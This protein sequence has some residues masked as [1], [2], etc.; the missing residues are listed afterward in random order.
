MAIW[1]RN[2]RTGNVW[3]LD[4]GTEHT[5]YVLSTGGYDVIPDP[6]TAPTATEPTPHAEMAANRAEKAN[7]PPQR[8]KR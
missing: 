6:T 8:R 4:D 7:R 2:K 1:V 5:R 3:R